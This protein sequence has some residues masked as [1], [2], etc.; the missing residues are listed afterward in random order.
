VGHGCGTLPED[1][2]HFILIIH[3]ELSLFLAQL[4]NVPR[5]AG[6]AV[7]APL[8][9]ELLEEED[10]GEVSFPHILL[11]FLEFTSM[12]LPDAES[13]RVGKYTG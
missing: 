8:I 12:L 1:P 13:S 9:Q 10:T 6:G 7:S 3:S 11:C 4:S 5:N 2:D